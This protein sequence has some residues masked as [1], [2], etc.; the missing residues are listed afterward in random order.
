MADH[1]LT[2]SVVLATYN[3]ERYL[4]ELLDSLKQQTRLPDELVVCDD[5]SSDETL[6]VVR[7]FAGDAPFPVYIH[8][9]PVNLGFNRNFL[10]GAARCTGDLIAFCDQDDVWKP[11]KLAVCARVFDDTEVMIAVHAAEVVDQDLHPLGYAVHDFG[12]TRVVGPLGA[13]P[14]FG[15]RG[16]SI[17]CRSTLLKLMPFEKRPR[18][19]DG[20]PQDY[21]EWIGF[22]GN[23]F[24]KTAYLEARLVLYRQHGHSVTAVAQS[25]KL[26]PTARRSA[27]AGAKSYA[28]RVALLREYAAFLQECAAEA[29]GTQRKRLYRAVAF[30][31]ALANRWA[32]RTALYTSRPLPLLGIPR[33][34]LLLLRGDYRAVLGGGLGLTGLVKDTFVAVTGYRP[35]G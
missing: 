29:T 21:D 31:R 20:Q 28:F 2:I 13:D 18:N 34:L 15:P 26:L 14:F 23:V 11:E 16:F 35:A 10:S 32:R 25:P 3:G 1:S 19:V 4:P 6:S 22:L 7:S 5:G 8:V 30:Y 24:G 9:N 17:V 33:V 12:S 27:S